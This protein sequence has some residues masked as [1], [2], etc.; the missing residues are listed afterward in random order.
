M[1][2]VYSVLALVFTWTNGSK[3]HPWSSET[4]KVRPLRSE[5]SQSLG[6][7]VSH[8]ESSLLCSQDKS[9]FNTNDEP[10]KPKVRWN[11]SDPSSSVRFFSGWAVYIDCDSSSLSSRRQGVSPSLLPHTLSPRDELKR[12]QGVLTLSCQWFEYITLGRYLWSI[13]RNH[14][15]YRHRTRFSRTFTIQDQYLFWS[16]LTLTGRQ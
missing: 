15:L 16:I 5:M 13:E 12:E 2:P 4:R 8:R 10:V 6:S 9:L 14:R 3:R 11:P 1:Y 7:G